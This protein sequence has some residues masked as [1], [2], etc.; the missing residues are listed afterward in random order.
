[1]SILT[2][3][4]ALEADGKLTRFMPRR[5][6]TPRRR[7]YLAAPAL[8]DF[9]DRSSAVNLL[10][11][12]GFVEASL[13]RWTIGDRIFGSHRR[14]YFLDRLCP[15]P[16]EIWEIRVT[17]PTVQARLFG[18]FAGP[19]TL[20]LTKF[21]TRQLLGKKGSQGWQHAMAECEKIWN[22]LFD[23]SPFSAETVG[24]YVTENC[25]DFPLH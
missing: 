16:P 22:D 23:E 14:G 11:G 2:T 5:G 6:Q 8:K 1:M 15:P 9:T 19:N 20:I 25:D 3:I 7:L 18:R 24:E 10:V 17:E 4:P 21:Y 13:T 12:R